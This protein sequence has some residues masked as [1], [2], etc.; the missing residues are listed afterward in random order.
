MVWEFQTISCVIP[1]YHT[2]LYSMPAALRIKSLEVHYF[3]TDPI[4]L[5]GKCHNN[6]TKASGNG[7]CG[8]ASCVFVSP[9]R[10]GDR[11]RERDG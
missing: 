6:L 9:E 8:L 1:W 5:A 2:R 10:D 3:H 11:D 7:L 4:S